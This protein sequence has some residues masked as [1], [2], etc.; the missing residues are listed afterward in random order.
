MSGRRRVGRQWS[1]ARGRLRRR[2]RRGFGPPVPWPPIPT[3]YRELNVAWF[4]WILSAHRQ[5]GVRPDRRTARPDSPA[6]SGSWPARSTRRGGTNLHDPCRQGHPRSGADRLHELLL[7]GRRLHGEHP[8]HRARR[9]ARRRHGHVR[10]HRWLRHG[11]P[12]RLPRARDRFS[13]TLPA[14]NVFQAYGIPITGLVEDLYG[15]GYWMLFDP[16]P[17]GEHTVTFGGVFPDGF[18][19]DNTYTLTVE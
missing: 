4:Q 9:E 3:T 11:G 18:S 1:H 13:A 7:R 15:G 10:D 16:L 5:P 6:T 19:N 12:G 14:G 8:A 2:H 17:P